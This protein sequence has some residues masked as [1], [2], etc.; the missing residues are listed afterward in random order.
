MQQ[1]INLKSIKMYVNNYVGML[2][3]NNKILKYI[4]GEKFIKAPFI[5][6]AD[7]I[8]YQNLCLRK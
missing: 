8:I 7:I 4:H 2:K 5:I 6:Y 3:E 1:K